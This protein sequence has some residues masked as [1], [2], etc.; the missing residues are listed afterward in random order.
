MRQHA[1]E[2]FK[3]DPRKLEEDE[4]AELKILFSCCLVAWLLFVCFLLYVFK[5]T[6]FS[7]FLLCL[8]F[9]IFITNIFIPFDAVH[10]YNPRETSSMVLTFFFI[11]VGMLINWQVP[12]I[13]KEM[14]HIRKK[15]FTFVI[16]S[17]GTIMISMVDISILKNEPL[18]EN[19][20]FSILNNASV[21]LLGVAVT[22]FFYENYIRR[23]K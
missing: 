18:I 14:I 11:I 21:I 19:H 20:L 13:G 4:K 3:K 23:V 10:H 5:L 7:K 15:L 9:F 22:E 17:F 6:L 8:P 1:Y 2:F 12:G 16:M